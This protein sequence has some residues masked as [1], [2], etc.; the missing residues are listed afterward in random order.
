MISEFVS[1]DDAA[2][3]IG[4]HRATVNRRIANGELEVFVA[5]DRRRRLVRRL[6]L[7][8]LATPRPVGRYQ[9]APSA[10]TRPAS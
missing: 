8:R 10:T 4:C 9:E 1:L 6:D 7:V 2:K 3:E 5:P